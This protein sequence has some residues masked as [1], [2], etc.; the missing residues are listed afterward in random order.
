MGVQDGLFWKGG[1]EGVL[2][3]ASSR[4][5]ESPVLYGR[6]FCIYEAIEQIHRIHNLALISVFTLKVTEPQMAK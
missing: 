3:H 5:A 1:G 2:S 4:H 6:S